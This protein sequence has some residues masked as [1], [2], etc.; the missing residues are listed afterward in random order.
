MSECNCG[1]YYPVPTC[2]ECMPKTTDHAKELV[3]KLE[4]VLF[5]AKQ[6]PHYRRTPDLVE[7]NFKVKRIVDN[8]RE[9]L[10]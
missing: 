5:E 3:E 8:Y 10:K 4:R 2:P 6:I 7:F 1:G 9:E